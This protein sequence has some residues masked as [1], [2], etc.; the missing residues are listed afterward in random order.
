V[1]W[2]ILDPAQDKKTGKGLIAR[3]TGD[4]LA[5]FDDGLNLE[6]FQAAL[7]QALHR[8][9]TEDYFFTG[10]SHQSSNLPKKIISLI[11]APGNSL[12]GRGVVEFLLRTHF[13]GFSS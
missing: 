12:E 4:D 8:M 9:A 3:I 2:P 10:Y 1:E 6:R 7:E 5:G 11:T 13:S